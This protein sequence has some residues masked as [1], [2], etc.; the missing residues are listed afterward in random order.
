MISKHPISNM[1]PKDVRLKRV[2]S[3]IICESVFD[4][5]ALFEVLDRL[6][7]TLNGKGSMKG[8]RIVFNLPFYYPK[9]FSH[10]SQ[11]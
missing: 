11:A 3:N 6:E 1:Q 10:M 2:M 7:V 9:L 5:F 4:I 8:Y